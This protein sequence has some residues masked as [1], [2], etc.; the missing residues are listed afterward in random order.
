MNYTKDLI[1]LQDKTLTIDNIK[2]TNLHDTDCFEIY[3]HKPIENSNTY[4]KF[5]G[6]VSI[7]IQGYHL[8]RIKYLNFG[9]ITSY[10]LYNQRRFKCKDC[11]KTFNEDCSIVDK[12]STISYATKEAIQQDFK[13]K[14]SI[15]DIA[16]KNN[17]SL[18]TA[19]QNFIN[20][21][22]VSRKPLTEFICLDE[23]KAATIA[24]KYALILGDPISGDI[25]DILP[26]RK[27]EYIYAYFSKIP[28][29]ER[30]S[31]KY[32]VTD[33]YESYRTIAK[34]LFWKSVHI[35][36]RFHWIRLACLALDKIRIQTMNVYQKAGVESN[37]NEY[38][39][40]YQI[41]KKY[42]KLLIA[43]THK[44]EI[45]YFDT[46]VYVPQFKKNMT[47]QEIIEFIVNFDQDLE[48]AYTLLQELYKIAKYSLYE[49]ADKDILDWCD[50]IKNSDKNLFSFK[51]VIST[52][53]SWINEIKNSFLFNPYTKSR[54][55]NGFIEGKNNFCKVIK[56][57][58]FGYKNFDLFRAKIIY[59]SN[60]KTK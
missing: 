24:G 9:G 58:G 27:Q 34:N 14:Q 21:V 2:K 48:E 18:S 30:F 36:D 52:Y 12:N 32:F 25:I 45:S 42:N 35:A 51:S 6:S 16:D 3:V 59:T 49:T 60:N 4:C 56:R 31:V 29:E 43:N 19:S 55:T 13:T 17:V 53:K 28:D 7:V 10:V 5:C 47:Y 44:K 46:T 22:L 23:F 40:F 33:L 41:A 57:V 37:N 39:T 8:R 38:L 54:I 20:E 26:S 15:T 1:N 50:K 11:H